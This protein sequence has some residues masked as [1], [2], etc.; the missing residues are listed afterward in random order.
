M[1]RSGADATGRWS[2]EERDLLA[3]YE[4]AFSEP[5]DRIGGVA[6]MVDTDNTATQVRSWLS[7]LRLVALPV[8][9][10]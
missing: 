10:D 7:D 6:F 9:P 8:L 4:R 2:A 1:L 3:D 5:P